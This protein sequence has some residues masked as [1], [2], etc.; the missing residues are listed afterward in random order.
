MVKDAAEAAP[1]VYTVVFEN[2]RVRLLEA[3]VKPGDSSAMHAHPNYLVYGLAAPYVALLLWRRHPRAR[4]AAYVFLSHETVRAAHFR[5]GD[6]VAVA[7]LGVVLLQLPSARRW[8]P[9]LRPAEIR[10]RLRRLA[11]AG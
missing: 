11:G 2:E 1:N 3:R 7:L 10:A 5:H 8:A 6:A 4:F 9:S